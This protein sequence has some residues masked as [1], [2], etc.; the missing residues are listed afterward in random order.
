[1]DILDAIISEIVDSFV[2]L[3]DAFVGFLP[4]L[5]TALILFIIGWIIAVGLGKLVRQLIRALKVDA[6]LE[7]LGFKSIMDRAGLKL[8]SGKFFDELVKWFVVLVALMV[9]VEILDLPQVTILLQRILLYVPN[10]IVSAIILL[11]GVLVAGL[12]Q[13]IVTASVEAAR[14]KKSA[15]IGTLAKWFI[16]IFAFLSALAE[17]QIAPAEV[18]F[19]GL[20]AALAIAFGLALGLGGKD[21]AAEFLNKI[22][23]EIKE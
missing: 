13:K 4:D 11:A 23:S 20:I 14:L 2:T 3:W 22:R 18:L 7:K 5:I 15:L 6:A 21:I 9:V 17:L 19:T 16:L 8:D 10:V 1:M 12:V